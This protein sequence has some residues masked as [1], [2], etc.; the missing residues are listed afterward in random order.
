MGNTAVTIP[1][2]DEQRVLGQ[3]LE[4][5]DSHITF[6]G[7]ITEIDTGK[8][9]SDYMNSR[10]EKYIKLL[11]SE[12][13]TQE[14]LERVETELHKTFAALSREEQNY[15]DI[16]LHDIQRGDVKAE[17]GKT[18]RDYI[19]E[20]MSKAKSDQIHQVSVV[21]GVN[22]DMLRNI[23]S[24]KLNEK[25]INEFGRY[26][27]LKKTVDKTKAKAY[28]EKIEGSKVIPPKVNIKVD[29]LLREFILEGGCE[30]PMPADDK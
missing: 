24:L 11:N 21:L 19:N 22:E 5:L 16:F 29:R 30:I 2:I 17:D 9:N 18:L 28:F 20:Y 6:V 12:G 8:I 23:M 7:H 13:T 27:E 14:A 15:A 1:I 25:N 10:F 26:D 3:Y 4:R